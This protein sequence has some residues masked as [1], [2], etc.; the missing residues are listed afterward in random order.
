MPTL[1]IDGR[2]VKVAEGANLLEAARAAGAHVPTLCHHPALEPSGGC[3]LCLVD[4]TR[5]GWSGPPKMVTACL[6]PAEDGLVVQ[7]ASPRVVATRRVVVDLLL[8]RCPETPI[9]QELA[10]QHGI[11]AT[12]YDVNPERTDC[13][14][15]GLCTR[16]CDQMGVSAIASVSRGA[17][18]SIAPPFDQP[19]P[20]CIG[21]LACAEVCPTGH[22]SV[23]ES[24]TDRSVWGRSFELQRCRECGRAQL[25]KA[26]V[27]WA[28]ARGASAR[29]FEL[30]DECKR[31]N[32]ARTLEEVGGTVAAGEALPA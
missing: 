30:C 7:T 32:L 2:T 20:D 31:R 10:R 24:L 6:Y 17:G 11:E 12:S 28:V 15:C 27:A 14:L 26:Q 21:C 9:V 1:R 18:R 5:E 19:P 23:A 16:A 3:R 4:V 13:V 25:T 29:D 22:V 8:A